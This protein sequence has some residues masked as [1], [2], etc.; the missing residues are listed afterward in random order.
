[1]QRP[2]DLHSASLGLLHGIPKAQPKTEP[3]QL[4]YCYTCFDK[5]G[6]KACGAD[7]DHAWQNKFMSL[8]HI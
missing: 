8:Q 2:T 7:A 5:N 3:A 4:T 1:M 6:R